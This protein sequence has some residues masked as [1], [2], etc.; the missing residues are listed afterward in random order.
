MV[1]LGQTVSE[2]SEERNSKNCGSLYAD[3]PKN[4]VLDALR[5]DLQLA[6]EQTGE[7]GGSVTRARTKWVDMAAKVLAERHHDNKP[8]S[9]HEST[10]HT[11]HHDGFTDLWRMVL[12]T[13]VKAEMYG[14]TTRGWT[15]VRQM[16]TLAGEGLELGKGKPSAWAWSQVR[17]E[18]T[19]LRRDYGS[20][21]AGTFTKPIN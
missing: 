21:M 20:G 3:V 11:T 10:K 17:E 6:L 12:W 16:V 2:R 4:Y 14:G 9:H 19:A 15:L 18:V 5:S 8:L 7:R 13:A 1:K